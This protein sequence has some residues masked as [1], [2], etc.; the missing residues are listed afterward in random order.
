MADT[1]NVKKARE[2]VLKHI[3]RFFVEL[4]VEVTKI[5]WASK[6]VTQKTSVA[7]LTFCVI[8]M[9]LISAMDFGFS[10]LFNLVFK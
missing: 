2:P 10:H 8:Y 3:A 7:V 5:T 4:K 1:G 9:L 6:E